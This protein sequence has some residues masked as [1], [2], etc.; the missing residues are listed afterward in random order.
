[1]DQQKILLEKFFKN[2]IGNLEQVDDLVIFGV[3]Y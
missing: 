1:M 3:E 2:W